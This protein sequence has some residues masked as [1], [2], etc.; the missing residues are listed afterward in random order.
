M[1]TKN[2]VGRIADILL[3]AGH[4]IAVAESVTSGHLQA[5]LSLA[6]YAQDFYQGG[7]TV[8]N[9]GQKCRH[10]GVEPIHAQ[11]HNAVSKQVAEQMA[12]G[13]TNAFSSH[14]GVG[15]CGYAA[16]VPELDVKVPFAFFAIAYSGT[17]KVSR[18]VVTDARSG[19]PTQEYYAST[20]LRAF[21]SLL[22]KVRAR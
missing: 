4:T 19:R 18:K 10:L 16:P 8:Y 15:I 1:Y 11:A 9:T 5:A 20:V 13:V 22:K 2:E 12:L 14:W 17:V 7:I 3:K 6:D 21:E